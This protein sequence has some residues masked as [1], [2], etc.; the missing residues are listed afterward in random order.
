MN[1][2]PIEYL[3]CLDYFEL[4]KSIYYRNTGM[5]NPNY[6]EGIINTLWEAG[7]IDEPSQWSSGLTDKGRALKEK[8]DLLK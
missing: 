7:I 4:P 8:Y 1:K 6:V 3:R 2:I 5:F